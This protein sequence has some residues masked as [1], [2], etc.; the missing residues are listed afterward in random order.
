MPLACLY[1]VCY[2]FWGCVVTMASLC[3]L[4]VALPVPVQEMLLCRYVTS[5]TIFRAGGH[6]ELTV[7]WLIHGPVRCLLKA[8]PLV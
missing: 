6:F 5:S 4:V 2:V 3:A 8:E 1:G 7:P